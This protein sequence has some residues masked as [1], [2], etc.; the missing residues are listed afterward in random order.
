MSNE[1]N[2]KENTRR[3]ATSLED[4]TVVRNLTGN[5]TF[6]IPQV[7]RSG[8]TILVC[9]SLERL[10]SWLKHPAAGDNHSAVSR[11]RESMS[12][13][14]ILLVQPDAGVAQQ[15]RKQ[16]EGAGHKV[17]IVASSREAL[18]SVSRGDFA[19]MVI[20]YQLPG[21]I[22]GLETYA[23]LKAEGYDLP[24]ILVTDAADELVLLKSLRAGVGDFSV[25]R[26]DT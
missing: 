17:V 8:L 4:V 6:P 15:Q 25:V 3:Q 10:T 20:E 14:K 2:R 19:L 5:R 22:D 24:V 13:K 18:D 26:Q 11:A 9:V 21:E 7:G 16:L 12:D 1:F 23:H